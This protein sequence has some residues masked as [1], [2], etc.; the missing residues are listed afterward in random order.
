MKI[1]TF[2]IQIEHEDDECPSERIFDIIQMALA[3]NDWEDY[4]TT[5]N[6]EEL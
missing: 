4:I 1:S 6:K 5:R 3:D 2:E